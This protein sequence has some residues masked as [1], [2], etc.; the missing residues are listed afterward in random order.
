[1]LKNIIE[2]QKLDAKLLALKRDLEKDA[3][4]QTLNKVVVLVKDSQNKLLELEAKAKSAISEYEKNKAEYEKAYN[5]L[6]VLIK[7]DVDSMTEAQLNE[8]IEKANQLVSFLGSLERSLSSQAEN[9]STIVKNFETC[10]NNIVLYKQKYKESKLACEKLEESIKPKVEEIKKQKLEMEKSI[11]PTLLN[12]YKHL[13]QDKIFPVFVPLNNNSCG[14][15]SMELPAA[16]MNKLK[17]EGYLECE[18]C[19]RYIY[20]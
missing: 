3:S 13:R 17:A 2:Y 10:R 14:G 9:V 20:I 4:K 12:K 18:Q 1:M 7:K 8:S 16:L 5:Q 6:N 15:C 19:R 11:D